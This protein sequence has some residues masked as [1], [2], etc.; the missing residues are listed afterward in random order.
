MDDSEVTHQPDS[1]V[2]FDEGFNAGGLSHQLEKPRFVVKGSVG[3]GAHEVVSEVLF[4][5]AHV[6][7]LNGRDIRTVERRELIKIRLA[8]G[9]LPPYVMEATS[10]SAPA[11]ANTRQEW[12]PFLRR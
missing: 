11:L 6:A 2:I 1:D 3:I 4:E 8:H 12:S 7:S 10:G 5:P 9:R